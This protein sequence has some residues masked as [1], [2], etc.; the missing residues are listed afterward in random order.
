MTKPL[1]RG[2]RFSELP[3]NYNHDFVERI[4]EESSK[5]YE[6]TRTTTVL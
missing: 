3:S 6:P 5:A 1:N 4:G 2:T